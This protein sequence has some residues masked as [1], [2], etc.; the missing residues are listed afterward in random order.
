MI[1]VKC[2]VEFPN[3]A[4]WFSEPFF[5]VWFFTTDT[6][7]L[8]VI[9]LFSFSIRYSVWIGCVPIFTLNYLSLSICMSS[10]F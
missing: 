7:S 1:S 8:L 9:G 4:I 5:I 2:L 6:M 3:E 10:F